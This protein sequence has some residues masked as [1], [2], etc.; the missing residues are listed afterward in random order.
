MEQRYH[1]V[2]EVLGSLVP[3]AEV[4]ERYGVSRQSVHVWLRRYA[5]GGLPGLADR[6]HRPRSH[7][8]QLDAAVTAVICQ[9]RRDHPRW[10]PRR[11]LHELR[12]R[13]VSPVPSRSTVYRVLVREH[14]VAGRRRR[15]P[16]SSFT[17]WQRP[18]PMMLWQLDITGKV[19][20]ADGTELKL[21]T[22]IDDHSRFV[23]IAQVVRRATG[24][25]VC[26]AFASALV[27]Y[28]CPEQVL[29]DNGKQFTGKFNRPRPAEVLF[30]RMCRKNGIE[31]LLTAFR[32]PTTTGKIERWHQTLQQEWLQDQQPCPDLQA[33]QA[34]VDAFRDE[35]NT[36]RPHQALDMATPAIAIP[37][38][39]A[40]AAGAAAGV[41]AA[42]VEPCRDTRTGP[43]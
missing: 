43:G 14:L 38:G 24:R 40:R 16:R 17:P 39:P 19:F 2:M 11:L 30:D 27:G 33:A 20:L 35:Y 1:A 5:E 29:T 15:R 13:G 25:A 3:V 36:R 8:A 34:M 12:E 42:G 6:S 41:A 18:G 31:H 4:A 21:V 28:G 37:S 32:H 22:G 26:A 23:V 9:L 7:P 10:G